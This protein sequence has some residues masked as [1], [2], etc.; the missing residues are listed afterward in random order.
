MIFLGRN[1]QSV[2]CAKSAKTVYSGREINMPYGRLTT[3]DL[4]R[5]IE[6]MPDNCP[7]MLKPADDADWTSCDRHKVKQGTA[8]LIVEARP[9]RP[10]N[11][12]TRMIH[13]AYQAIDDRFS[14]NQ[15]L[16]V[17]IGEDGP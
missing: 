8:Y 10:W 1:I 6:G 17:E 9:A 3:G 4:R 12:S 2:A 11:Y 5:L 13:N 16:L 7:V 14:Q 15:I